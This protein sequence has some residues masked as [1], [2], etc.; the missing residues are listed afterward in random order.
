MSRKTSGEIHESVTWKDYTNSQ[1]KY[2]ILQETS[3]EH[4]ET[5]LYFIKYDGNEENLRKLNEQLN[6]VRFFL[7]DDLSTFDLEMN[8]LVSEKTAKE[9]TRVDLN[10]NSFH[11]KFDGTLREINFGLEKGW[12]NKK[13][14]GKIF[15]MIG[16]GKIENYIDEEDLEPEDLVDLSSEESMTESDCSTSSEEET[17]KKRERKKGKIPSV[18]ARRRK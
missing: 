18:L 13:K 9:M 10:K 17:E 16:Q 4:G 8:V 12:K 14:M 2:V 7:R 15:D 11:R 6:S 3:D 1:R 5:W